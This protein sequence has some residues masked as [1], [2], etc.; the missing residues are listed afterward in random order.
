MRRGFFGRDLEGVD[1][2]I[3]LDARGLDGLAGFLADGAG[4]LFAAMPDALGDLAKDGGAL[5]G[6]HLAGD[7]KR[8]HGRLDGGLHVVARSFVNHGDDAV[9]VRAR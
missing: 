4:E 3:D 5:K 9:V 8:L 1:A 6:R 7:G 2:A